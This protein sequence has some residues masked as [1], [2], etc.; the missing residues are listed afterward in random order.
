[1]VGKMLFAFLSGVA[2]HQLRPAT[3]GLGDKTGR[4][5][6]YVIG[7]ACIWLAGLALADNEQERRAWTVNLAL[8]ALGVG[9]GVGLAT[10]LQD[11][12]R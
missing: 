11:G 12:E 1:M 10:M 4:I 6:R 2:G 3:I 9:S 8:S 7:V 5:I